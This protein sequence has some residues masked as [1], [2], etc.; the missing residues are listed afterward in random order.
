[1]TVMQQVDPPV[2][3]DLA[4]EA[5]DRL[6]R[7]A[8][9]ALAATTG[10][11]TTAAVD[12]ALR[13]VD[14]LD[15]PAAVFVTLTKGGELRGCIGTLHP[16]RRLADAV[17]WGAVSAARRDPRFRPV[18]AAELPAIEIEISVLGAP[19]PLDDPTRFRPGIDGVI[20]ER[21][22]RVAILLPEVANRFRWGA[23]EMLAAV[24]S[25]AGLHHDAWRDSGT[26][27]TRFRTVRFG[28][29]AVAVVARDETS[30]GVADDL[31]VASPTIAEDGAD[32]LVAEDQDEL[33]VFEGRS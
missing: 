4:D 21:G 33:A 18:E 16:D 1:M 20:V 30:A 3:R 2:A 23:A 15:D 13:A 24:C 5:R 26:G 31:D 11:G 17:V 22:G 32:A 12:E 25:K 19:V 28:G 10:A 7:L 29:P 9:A 14:D 27:L 6:L 8:R